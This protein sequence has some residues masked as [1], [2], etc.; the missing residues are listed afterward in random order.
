[1]IFKDRVILW[2]TCGSNCVTQKHP[3]LTLTFGFYG[4]ILK[5]LPLV[6]QRKQIFVLF[7]YLIDS[8]LEMG[9]NL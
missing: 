1:M 7:D 3:A 2:H 9:H 4:H 5:I 6:S 8:T